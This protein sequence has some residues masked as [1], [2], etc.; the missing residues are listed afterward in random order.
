MA[1]HGIGQPNPVENVFSNNL[2][3]VS[4]YTSLDQR[5]SAT[6]ASGINNTAQKYI[7]DFSQTPI[8]EIRSN[9]FYAESIITELINEI[10]SNL[11]K[12]KINSYCNVELEKAH[13][14]VWKEVV[15]QDANAKSLEVPDFVSYEEYLYANQ[16]LSSSCRDLIKN[17]DL[18]ISHTTFGH[19]IDIK[20]VLTYIK[21][22]IVII[23]NIVIH[24]LGEKYKDETESQISKHLSDWAKTATHYTK[25]LAKE[26]TSATATIPQVEIQKITEK[27]AAQFQSFFGLKVNSYMSEIQ[28]ILNIIKRDSVDMAQTFYSNYLIPAMC[29]KSSVIE[30]LIFD[31]TTSTISQECPTLT[32]EIVVANNAIT[33]NLGSVTTDYIERRIQF[34][35]RMDGLLQSINLKRRYVNY[36]VQLEEVAIQRVKIIYT[37]TDENTE[38]YKNLFETMPIDS[39][40]RNALKA[41]HSQLDDLDEDSHP[42]YLRKDGGIITGKI[43]LAKGA[44]IGGIPISTH[45]HSGIDGSSPI[46]S[47]SIDYSTGR[48]DYYKNLGENGYSNLKLVRLEQSSLIGGGLYFDAT[49]EIEIE[50]DKTNSYEFEI[51][52]NEI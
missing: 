34:S 18:S 4:G 40:K 37:K 10:D 38:I 19:L 47:L 21:N 51:L 2:E 46:S 50:D 44:T 32:G 1:Q 3:T 24:H 8:T 25:Q 14:A 17:Y 9:V 45:A 41:S 31:F 13:K 29:F 15:K 33:G 36:I 12:V 26:I 52:Y 42:Q 20:K 6:N 23:K 28:T 30:P 48:N 5:Y 39:D 22:E 27:H 7:T 49:F 11:Q 35:S 43:E 16:N